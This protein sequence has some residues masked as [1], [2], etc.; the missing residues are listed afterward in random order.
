MLTIMCSLFLELKMSI[1]KSVERERNHQLWICHGWILRVETDK[2]LVQAVQAADYCTRLMTLKVGSRGMVNDEDF[3]Q[4]KSHW[5]NTKGNHRIVPLHHL[6]L[7]FFRIWRYRNT[8]HWP[9]SCFL[10]IH[11]VLVLFVLVVFFCCESR[12]RCITAVM[13]IWASSYFYTS[14]LIVVLCRCLCIQWREE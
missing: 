1:I 10:S 8:F 5:C 6:C 7:E 14:L 13:C 12:S 4:I 2:D 11:I 3:Q 9:V